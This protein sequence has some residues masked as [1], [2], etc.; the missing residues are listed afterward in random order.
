[1]G[2]FDEV[3]TAARQLGISVTEAELGSELCQA[4]ADRVLGAKAKFEA[5]DMEGCQELIG[6]A[7]RYAI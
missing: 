1:M 2:N 6:E 4:W 3:I 5:G 7:N